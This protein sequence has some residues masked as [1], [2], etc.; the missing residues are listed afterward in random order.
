[1]KYRGKEYKW[2]EIIFEDNKP[3]LVKLYKKSP[4]EYGNHEER[5]TTYW[6]NEKL[7]D[8]PIICEPESESGACIPGFEN[9]QEDLDKLTIRK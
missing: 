3:Q 2:Y 5:V 6:D 1:M 4:Y 9:M 7:T 8:K